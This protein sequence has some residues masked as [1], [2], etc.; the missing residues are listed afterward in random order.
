MKVPSWLRT[1]A[2]FI[3]KALDSATPED[4]ATITDAQAKLSGAAQAIES[5][6][7]VLAKVAVDGMLAALGGG[8]YIPA[9]NEFVDALIAE[10]ASRKT[11]A[12]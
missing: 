2:D 1:V 8:K 12:A 10:L 5:A 9:F 4:H 11:K 7:P 3:A 6:L